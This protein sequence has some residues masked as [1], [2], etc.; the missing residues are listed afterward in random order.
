MYTVNLCRVQTS[1]LDLKSCTSLEKLLLEAVEGLEV[2]K[3]GP[4]LQSVDISGCSSLEKVELDRNKGLE[5]LELGPS[6]QS[7]S[8]TGC[9]EL[10]EVCG[11]HRPLGLLSLKLGANRKLSKLSNL[12]GLKCLHTLECHGLDIEEVPGLDGLVGLKSLRVSDCGRLSKFPT[13]TRLHCLRKLIISGLGITEI[14][15]L[16]GLQQLE[17]V[18]ASR[19]R[20][21]TSL[22]G[23]GDLRA[24]KSIELY[25][26]ESL[27]RL[28]NMSKLTNLKWLN[29]RSTR[30]ELSVVDFLMLQG[31]QALEAI[32]L[33]DHRYDYKGHKIVIYLSSPTNFV[34]VPWGE[35]DLRD[36][37]LAGYHGVFGYSCDRA[38]IYLE[39]SVLR[40]MSK[41]G[42]ETGPRWS[43]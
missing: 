34:K 8:I 22:Q 19:N 43:Y 32:F 17:D 35:I 20:E 23:F 9:S 6:L 38:A 13:L 12:S 7:L 30:V 39:S 5:V 14:P 2:L 11:L 36:L 27:C 1:E 31:L 15:N 42:E 28:S 41:I 25:D 18:D 21:L 16:S 3:L 24:V 10:V 37:A 26:C 4:S 29:L 40:Y 33:R